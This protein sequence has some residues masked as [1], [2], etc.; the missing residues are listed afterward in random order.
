MYP[1]QCLLL[2]SIYNYIKELLDALL[3]HSI[4]QNSRN[5]SKVNF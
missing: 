4:F 5:F 1:L 2:I 3:E